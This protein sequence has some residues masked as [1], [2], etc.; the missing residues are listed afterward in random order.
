MRVVVLGAGVVGVCT[1]H[2][3]SR[4][5]HQVTVV[6]RLDEVAGE[7]SFANAG[8]VAP[9]H[10]Y[11]WASPRAP[12][13][14]LKSLFDRRQAL[15]FRPSLDPDL[16]IWSWRF[17][18]NCTMQRARQNTARKARL[19]R[20]S[21]SRLHVIADETRIE[22]HRVTGGLLYLYR[23]AAT[24][25]R[26]RGAM[27]I[28][29]DEGIELRVLDADQA[30]AIDQA[31]RG[32]RANIAGAIFAPTDES[33]DARLFTQAL[34]RL[35]A[36]RGIDY[37]FGVEVLGFETEGVKVLS[38]ITSKGRFEGDFFVLC[39]GVFAP[40]LGRMLG[41]SIPVY[42]IKGYSLTLPIGPGH[43]AP[44]IGGRRRSLGLP[45][46]LRRSMRTATAEFAGYDKSHSPSDFAHMLSSIRE[47][48][49]NGADFAKPTY[50]AGLRPMTPEGTP[51][52][53]RG[54]HENLYFNVGHGHMGWTMAAGSARITADL[55][56][57]LKP[58]I[59]LDGMLLERTE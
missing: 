28:L 50:W 30:V 7:T 54:S 57:G 27:R 6:E 21:Q 41:A 32:F 37:R 51:L 39:A 14:L 49:P 59:P 25:E 19:C 13:I 44:R 31:L 16:W 46:P 20:Y 18:R 1:A 58:E 12:K 52:F 8:L 5:G 4:D 43:E 45:C 55:V 23:D 47:L 24:F 10:A 48:F 15:R 17:L 34:A 36:S 22:F 38:L 53:G 2:E 56:S 29:A 35:D 11:A 26:G 3:L 40:R 33:G 9:G 42:P